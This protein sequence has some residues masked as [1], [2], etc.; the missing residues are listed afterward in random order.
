[1]ETKIDRTLSLAEQGELSEEDYQNFYRLIGSFRDCR[2]PWLPMPSCPRRLI[3]GSGGKRDSSRLRI[4]L[5]E[6][7][8][9]S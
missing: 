4:E 3:G 2:N 7:D 8:L 1:M 5:Y 6:I 9:Y